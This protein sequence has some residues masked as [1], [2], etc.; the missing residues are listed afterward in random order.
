MNP[1]VTLRIEIGEAQNDAGLTMVGVIEEEKEVVDRDDY[2]EPAVVKHLWNEY[3]IDI[4][5]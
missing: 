5:P 1:Q 3:G 4:E 2:V